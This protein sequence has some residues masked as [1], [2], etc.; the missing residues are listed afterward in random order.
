MFTLTQ[1]QYIFDYAMLSF[2]QYAEK[3][4]PG[5]VKKSAQVAA[6]ATTMV[7]KEANMAIKTRE[8][9]F[10]SGLEAVVF[11]KHLTGVA[12]REAFD[13]Q[14]AKSLK[15][16]FEKLFLVLKALRNM[17]RQTLSLQCFLLQ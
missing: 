7:N 9:V 17:I 13:N 8:T 15:I 16:G 11:N 14:F 12:H 3:T 4:R 10:T 1:V 6:A 5:A 2:Y